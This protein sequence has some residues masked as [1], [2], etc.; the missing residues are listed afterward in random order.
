LASLLDNN[1]SP[2]VPKATPPAKTP[3]VF[4]AALA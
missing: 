3:G 2:T 1:L 4:N